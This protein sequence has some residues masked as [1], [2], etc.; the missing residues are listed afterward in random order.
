M[1]THKKQKLRETNQKKK[2]NMSNSNCSKV[3]EQ[4]KPN[5]NYTQFSTKIFRGNS[6]MKEFIAEVK[7]DKFSFKCLKCKD[8]KGKIG[9]ILKVNS[10]KTRE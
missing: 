7:Q 4:K 10:L 3:Q 8:D 1:S 6:Y 5:G 2:Y 9:K